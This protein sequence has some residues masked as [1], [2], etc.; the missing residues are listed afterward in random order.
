L[1][2][3]AARYRIPLLESS[4]LVSYAG[5]FG[6]SYLPAKVPAAGAWFGGARRRFI[7]WLTGV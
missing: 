7:S 4:Y 2:G 1:T 3:V 6:E 5:E